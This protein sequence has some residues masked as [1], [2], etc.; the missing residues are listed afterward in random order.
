MYRFSTYKEQY[1]Q[2]L[3][4]ALPVVLTQ[5]GQILTQFTDNLMVGRY[6][7]NDP[8]PLAAVSFGGSV[9][10]ILFIASIG[11]AMGMTP[12]VGERYVQGDRIHSA[13]LLQNG[14]LFYGLLGVAM[15]AIQYAAIPLLYHM[16]QPADVVD[17]AIPYYKM[18]VWSM[19]PVMLF[20]AFKQF[21]E[22]VGN[23][24]AEMYATIVA[25]VANIGFNWI[26]IYGHWGFPEMG[27]EGAG[28]GTLL[29]RVIGMAI[30][31]GY[32]CARSRYR[33]YFGW[34]SWR[35]FSLR[36]I[37]ELFRMGGPISLQMFLESSAFVG[38]GIMMGWF[39]K[40]TLSAN[41]ITMTIGNCAFMIVMSI[42]AATT[43]RV[44]H[45]YGARNFG[46]LSLAA[47]ASY[48]LVL[49]WNALAAVL[50]ISLRHVIPTLFTSNPEVIAITS[51]LLVLAALYQL[52]DGLQNVS[53]GI[54]R[55]I[56]DVRIIMPIA[57][58]S[59]W[60][61]NLPVGY[62][63]GFTLGMGPSGLFLGFSFGLSAAALLMILRIRHSVR[64]L[65]TAKV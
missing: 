13:R 55:G 37:G 5:L 63:L 38:T 34:F 23:T 46:E 42:G 44:S 25:N 58:V 20:F 35:G 11:I 59:Y 28:L 41:Q 9:F 17:M 8:L 16:R 45:C 47:R 60:L 29:A 64:R 1:R 33:Q 7:G 43:I 54:L 30:M 26:F 32:F 57:F 56:Q 27:A 40:Q 18:L 15:S 19:P 12:L 51:Q 65:R 36:R 48:H 52:S 61:L 50:F 49:A 31:I 14:I 10:F 21:L 53:V 22:G 24:R 3:R 62:L 4:L 6:G 2:N 39:D